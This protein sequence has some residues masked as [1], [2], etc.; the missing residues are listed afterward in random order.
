[1]LSSMQ[2]LMPSIL[3]K[4]Q[5][6]VVGIRCKRQKVT[7]GTMH[8]KTVVWPAL[9]RSVSLIQLQLYHFKECLYETEPLIL[10]VVPSYTKGRQLSYIKKL[11]FTQIEFLTGRSKLLTDTQ[12]LILKHALRLHKLTTSWPVTLKDLSH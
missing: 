4:P 11:Y 12:N 2:L 10:V 7:R 1:M 5:I 9:S 3:H 8:Y 6:S